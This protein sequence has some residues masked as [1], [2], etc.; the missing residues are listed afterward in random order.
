VPIYEYDCPKCG[1][2]DVIQR[3]SDKPLRRHA[4]CGSRVTKQISAGTFAFKSSGFHVTDYQNGMGAAPACGSP[5]DDACST[6][7]AAGTEAA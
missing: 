3:M 7:P 4:E 6:C 1:R 2:F 5:K